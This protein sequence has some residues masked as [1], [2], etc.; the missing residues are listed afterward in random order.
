MTVET[1]APS[2]GNETPSGPEQTPP[3][4][5]QAEAPVAPISEPTG[6][7]PS[8][9]E[10][11]QE[12][13]VQRVVPAADGY[14]LG[15]GV[16]AQLGEIFNKLDM[17]QEQAQGVLKLDQ[18][19]SAA[20]ASALR[21]AGEAHIKSWGESAETNINLAKRGMNHFDPT[22]QLKQVLNDTGYGN[23]PRLLEMFF[24]FGRR[25][26]EGGFLKSA[27]NTPASNPKDVAHMWY[28]KDAP[29]DKQ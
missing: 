5:A 25:M 1:Q 20:M 2:Q 14:Q 24:Q 15:E 29:K 28:P 21:T 16:P 27:V 19:R 6:T 4:P 10:G 26:E 9:T 3:N 13:P 7:P 22:G 12:A 23:D 17:T 18:A 8:S 11:E